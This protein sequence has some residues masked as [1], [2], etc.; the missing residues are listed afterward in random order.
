MGDVTTL[1]GMVFE[2]MLKYLPK[3]LIRRI[4]PTT[5]IAQEIRIDLRS[6]VPIQIA[7]YDIPKI[8]LYF[9]ITNHSLVDLV[10]DRLLIEIHI[11][12][13]PILYGILLERHN[14]PK[15]ETTGIYFEDLLTSLQAEHLKKRTSEIKMIEYLQVDVK[16]YFES[17]SGII[18]LEKSNL[19]ARNVECDL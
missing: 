19:S 13:Q 4:Y 5:R 7:R 14:I 2:K 17:N 18:K 11:S 15:R 12:S 1:T 3:W 6:N 16:A 8:S 9:T 10:L